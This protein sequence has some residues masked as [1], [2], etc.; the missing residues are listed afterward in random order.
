MCFSPDYVDVPWVGTALTKY[1]PYMYAHIRNLLYDNTPPQ[2]KNIFRFYKNYYFYTFIFDP[3]SY[4]NYYEDIN[5]S[6]T[7]D[8]FIFGGS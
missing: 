3:D 1:T 2:I 8:E 6:I 5:D 7:S 4:I